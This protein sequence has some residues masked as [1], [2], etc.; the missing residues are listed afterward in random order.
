MAHVHQGVFAVTVPDEKV[1][2]YRIAAVYGS[3]PDTHEEVRDDPY[4][5]LPT[6]GEFDLHLIAEGR[7]EELWRVLG[8]HVREVGPVN[9]TTPGAS[10]AVW[11]PNAHGVRVTGDFNYW[12]GRAYP[13]RSLG[14]SGVWE[15]FIPGVSDGA[16]YKYSVCGRDGVWRDKADPLAM[17]AERP[18]ATA[19]V[20]FTSGYSWDDTEWMA[21]RAARQPVSQPMSIYEARHRPTWVPIPLESIAEL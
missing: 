15:L 2:G 6:L 3:G 16:R 10:F 1:P 19:S 21:A 11:A 8:A 7:H 17:F 13:M 20:V 18:P 9:D 4:R 14:G 12:D 5:H